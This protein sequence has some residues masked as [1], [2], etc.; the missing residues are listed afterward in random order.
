M[1]KRAS[2]SRSL[3]LDTQREIVNLYRSP[4]KEHTTAKIGKILI[5]EQLAKKEP[6]S[7]GKR[8]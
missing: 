4:H 8:L 1:L 7:D 3:I 6:Y 2:E 5:G